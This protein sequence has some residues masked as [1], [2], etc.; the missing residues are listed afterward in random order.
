MTIYFAYCSLLCHNSEIVSLLSHDGES[1]LLYLHLHDWIVRNDE[2]ECAHHHPE[3]EKQI[4]LARLF[5]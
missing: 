4:L 3:R 5:L 1:F 2:R